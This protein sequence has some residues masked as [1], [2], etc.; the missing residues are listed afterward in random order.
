[1]KLLGSGAAW[2]LVGV[3][4]LPGRRGSRA[5]EEPIFPPSHFRRGTFCP[6]AVF[7]S[8]TPSSSAALGFTVKTMIPP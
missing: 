5:V 1:V 8:V 2:P 7:L 3:R 4:G 6:V